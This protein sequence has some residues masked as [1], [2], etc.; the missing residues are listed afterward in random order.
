LSDWLRSGVKEVSL[1]LLDSFKSALGIA[2][3]LF[4]D[5]FLEIFL[6]KVK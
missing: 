5:L 6:S 1:L 2:F 4:S 3:L